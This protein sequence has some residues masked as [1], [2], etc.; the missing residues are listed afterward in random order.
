M[1]KRKGK[2]RHRQK[3]WERLHRDGHV[4]SEDAETH[5]RLTRRRVRLPGQQQDEA[6]F[7]DVDS[8]PATATETTGVVTQLYPGGAI[9]RT[10]TCCDLMCGL[11]G[12]FRPAPGA[13]ALAVGDNVTI[14]LMPETQGLIQAGEKDID[15]DRVDALIRQ[16]SPRQTAL[17]RPQPMRGKRRDARSKDLFEKVI[18]ANMEQLVVVASVAH[19][20]LHRRLLDRFLIIAERGELPVALVMTKIDLG[21]PDLPLLQEYAQLGVR[22]VS[23]SALTGAGMEAVRGLLADRRSVLS[24]ASGVGKSSLLNTLA[25]LNIPTRQVRLRDDRGRHSTSAAK[26]YELPFGGTVV[27]T[28]GIRELGI[29]IDTA[30][31][32]WYFPEFD[33]LAPLCRFRNCT[34]THEPDCAVL[35]AVENGRVPSKRYHSYLLILDSIGDS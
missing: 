17:S 28:P 13:S 5:R 24:G 11:A 10:N 19:P 14:S 3:G 6:I 30:E 27:D 21:Q 12:T 35:A 34:H 32:P 9:V 15:G 18:A 1:A 26:L 29:E 23:C 7:A 4:D 33:Q 20:P 8:P 25:D 22:W 31:L 2:S 16:R